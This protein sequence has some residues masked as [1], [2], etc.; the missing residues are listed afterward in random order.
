MTVGRSAQ[1][2]RGGL[3]SLDEALAYAVQVYDTE[4]ATATMVKLCVEQVFVLDPATDGDGT[5]EWVTQVSGSTE[6]SA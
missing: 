5:Y 6:E 4:F 3:G 1:V 2:T